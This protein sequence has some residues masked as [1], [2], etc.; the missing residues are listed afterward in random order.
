MSKRIVDFLEPVQI[1]AEHGK[2]GQHVD[3]LVAGH[4]G[5]FEVLP[6]WQFGQCVVQ[7][8]VAQHLLCLFQRL[9]LLAR[10]PVGAF[11]FFMQQ[12]LV[13]NV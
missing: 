7:C 4:K 12:N 2:G 1:D 10:F 3:R 13:G 9:V 11:E 8:V 6:V 5:L